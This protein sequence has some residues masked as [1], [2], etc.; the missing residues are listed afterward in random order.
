[1]E[2][3]SGRCADSG[4]VFKIDAHRPAASKASILYAMFTYVIHPGDARD[5]NP[6]FQKI[7]QAAL[8]FAHAYR[9]WQNSGRM[10]LS[11]GLKIRKPKKKPKPLRK[12][13]NI[14][15]ASSRSS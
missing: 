13:K 9:F 11:N 6:P 2:R 15:R 8:F 3:F 1:M 12:R 14:T 5:L 4:D 10:F 7:N